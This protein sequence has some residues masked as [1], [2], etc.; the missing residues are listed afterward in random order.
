VRTTNAMNALRPLLAAALVAGGAL[1]SDHPHETDAL[2]VPSLKTG[3]SCLIRGATIHTAVG[4]PFVGDVLVVDGK[5]Q[6]VGEVG[7]VPE[8]LVEI[9]AEGMHLAPG[10]VDCHSHMA[11]E[12]GINEGTVSI[13]A[14]VDIS[15]SVD[16]D[17]LTIYRALAGGCTTARLLHGSANAIGGK[18]EV[19]KLKW[20]RTADELVF[21]GAPE[22]IKFA[23]GENV[24]RSNW[25]SGNSTRF[26]ASRMGTATLYQR[27]FERAREYAA[28]WDAYEAAVAAGE[29]PLPPRRD[30][31]LETLV[32]ILDREIAVHCHC[33]RADGILMII[34]V[35]QQFGFHLATLQHV[36]EGYKVAK[37]MADAGVGGSTFGDWWAYKMEAYDA[38]PQNAALMDRAGVLS[39]VNSDSDEMVRRM[40]GEAAKSVR[41]AGL[42]RVRALALVTINAARQLG[43][44][45]RVGSIEVGKDADLALLTGDPLSTLSRVELTL[46]DGEVEFERRD[47][48]GFDAAP[49]A[50]RELTGEMPAALEPD[51]QSPAP[52]L[53]LVGGTV[54][55]VAH[56]VIEEGTV[57]F[58]GRRILAVG[59]RDEVA[60]PAGTRTIITAGKHVWPGMIALGTDL[61]LHEIGAVRATEDAREI[62][63]NQPDV[64]TLR[65]INA[66][67]A[68][69]GVTRFNGITRAQVAPQSGGPLRGRSAVIDLDGDNW[70]ELATVEDDMLHLRFPTV[71]NSAKK[72]EMPEEVEELREL[73]A[74]ARRYGELVEAAAADEAVAPPLRD[75]RLEALLPA[76]SGEQKVALHASN[77]QTILFALKFADEEE[78]DAVLYGA[79]EG[80][81]VAQ[82]IAA[83]EV[84]VVV[85]PVL[86]LPT[87][88]F[89]P[90][91][92]P[93]ANAAALHAAGVRV[94]IQADDPDNTR[95]LP[96]HAAM[97]ACYGLPVEEAVRAVTLT[98]AE[99]LGLDDRLGSLAPGKLADILVTEGH[100]LEAAGS[101]DYVFI[102]GRQVELK[103]RQTDLYARYQRRLRQMEGAERR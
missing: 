86:A 73:F 44:E 31:R 50:A 54:H 30:L 98:P 35:A 43:I 96:L 94:A 16:S 25:G 56:G 61:G 20:G 72:K 9:P 97:A 92:A 34:R 68:H 85:G 78:L 46:V 91:D 75:P 41:Y 65:A 28:E 37:E 66:D 8:G 21:P 81:K 58:Q 90:Y 39:S 60:I 22:G 29:D 53:A 17:D 87:S 67:S 32:G 33:Y 18:H 99:L 3:G 7:E 42:D 101:V 23:L 40:Y 47:T 15:D 64:G 24:K 57:L 88:R 52:I 51:L 102:E 100:L 74:E 62:G 63:G 55:T 10:V 5:I 48:F 77:A 14:D 76:L 82:A 95:N 89:D 38:I 36:L 1:A 2:R 26:P 80:W 69:I 59:A 12:R 11:I 71:R 83:A 84:P 49:L 6:A 13:S 103:N 79:S 93:F 45:A 27:A 70:E 19:I 4:E